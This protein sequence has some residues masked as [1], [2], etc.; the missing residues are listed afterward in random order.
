MPKIDTSYKRLSCSVDAC[1][2]PQHN[3]KRALCLQ[4]AQRFYN[5]PAVADSDQT[6]RHCGSAFRS[7]KTAKFCSPSCRV[8]SKGKKEFAERKCEFCHCSFMP[9]MNTQL[10]CSRAHMKSAIAQRKTRDR[11]AGNQE[12]LEARVQARNERAIAKAISKAVKG[13]KKIGRECA[14]R[15][16]ALLK[17]SDRLCKT[18]GGAFKPA[19]GRVKYCSH[20]CVRRSPSRRAEKQQR[21]AMKRGANGGE[22]FLD[23]EVLE[24]DKWT[25]QLCGIKTP[26]SKRGTYAPNAPE[27]DHIV[28]I[29]KGGLHT[30]INTQ[31]ACRQCNSLKADKP[32]GQLLLVG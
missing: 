10:Y 12:K 16:K 6:C 2:S 3:G 14:K 1:E 29:S 20:A 4:H 15:M 27:L 31:C 5:G 11:R 7:R 8:K 9:L 25:C 22:A 26:K 18:C 24:R 32:L 28:P 30:R 23:I 19:N 17:T 13:A 21:K